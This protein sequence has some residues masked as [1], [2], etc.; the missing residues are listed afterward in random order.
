MGIPEEMSSVC[1]G[2]PSTTQ[3]VLSFKCF[4]EVTFVEN[5]YLIL[6]VPHSETRTWRLTQETMESIQWL[7]FFQS[8]F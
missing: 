4:T 6:Y 3:T 1:G 5:T 8:F 2:I 7:R